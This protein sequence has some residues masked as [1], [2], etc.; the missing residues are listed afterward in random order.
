MKQPVLFTTE[1]GSHI[2]RM[3]RP[4]SDHDFYTAYQAPTR[5]IL[6]G[7]HK[8]GGDHFNQ[9]PGYDEFRH[10]A[11]TVAMQLA[12][13]NINHIIGVMSPIVKQDSKELQQLRKLLEA[14]PSKS[15]YHSAR[16]LAHSNYMKYVLTAK[17]DTPKKRGIIM[18]TLRFAQGVI[19][20]GVYEFEPVDAASIQIVDL[21][22]AF[23]ALEKAYNE[24]G[25]RERPPAD[26][27]HDWLY[28]VRY[29]DLIN[30]T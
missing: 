17:E 24:P 18:R 8:G 4:D 5:D 19:E 7:R 29:E 10:E 28:N 15:I 21:E 1:V 26:M 12:K 27:F 14:Y 20:R 13:G 30:S 9:Q 2:W 16:G 11:E 25:L 22:R 3:N 6:A 23:A